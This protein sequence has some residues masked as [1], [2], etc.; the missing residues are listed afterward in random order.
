MWG[1]VDIVVAAADSGSSLE[2]FSTLKI[3]AKIS[4]ETSVHTRYT[5]RHI[6][7]DG[8][9]QRKM[10]SII[11]VILCRLTDMRLPDFR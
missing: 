11:P 8:I 6:P 7:E 3:E 1:R 9:L 2:D 5:R 10:K 4:S